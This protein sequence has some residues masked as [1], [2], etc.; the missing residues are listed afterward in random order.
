MITVCQA[1]KDE[2]VYPLPLSKV[3]IIATKR[4]FEDTDMFSR[5]LSMQNSYKG[6]LADCYYSLLQTISFSEGGMSVG[7]LTDSQRKSVLAMANNL[8]KEIGE[9][10]VTDPLSPTVYINC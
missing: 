3:E 6:A 8:Y 7:A 4:G 9:P 5:E 1:L 2:I 10:E